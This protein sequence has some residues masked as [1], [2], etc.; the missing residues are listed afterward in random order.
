VGELAVAKGV[1]SF[2]AAVLSGLFCLPTLLYGGWLLKLWIAI[3]LQRCVYLEYSYLTVGLIFMALAVVSLLC[4]LY[5]ARRRGYWSALFIVPVIAGVWTMATIPN[6]VP[7]DRSTSSHL[8]AVMTD[9]ETFS[10]EHGNFPDRETALP[11]GALNE[12]GPYYQQGRRLPFRTVLIPKA[13]GP[14]LNSAGADPG[15]VFY[16]VS[17]NQQEAWLTGTELRFPRPICGYAQFVDFLS[18][19]GDTRVLHL[20]AKQAPPSK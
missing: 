5:A 2:L 13:T 11:A 10:A 3:Q 20:L 15:V 8:R 14:F 4:A 16:A 17:A 12:P 19:D 6:I 7:Y 18:A 9:L 1:V